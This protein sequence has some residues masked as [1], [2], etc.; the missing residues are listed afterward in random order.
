MTWQHS[1][2]QPVQGS[3]SVSSQHSQAL[4]INLKSLCSS[5]VTGCHH[6]EFGFVRGRDFSV[7]TLKAS[8]AFSLVLCHLLNPETL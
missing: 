6:Q 2:V 1:P 5:K 4:F 8:T 3:G 7:S